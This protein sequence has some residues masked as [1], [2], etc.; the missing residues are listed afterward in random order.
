M[1]LT[2][3]PMRW[4]AGLALAILMACTR[5]NHFASIHALPSASWAVFFLA[6]AMLGRWWMYALYFALASLLDFGSLA[7][8]TIT[9][10]CLSPAYWVLLPAYGTLW[11]C[12]RFYA[13][14]HEQHWQT[15]PRLALVLVVAVFFTYL[16]SGGGYYMLSGHYAP[17]LSGFLPRIAH[18]YP[19]WL[20]VTAGYVGAALA[21][22]A[23]A[24]TL[25]ERS[26]RL[27]QGMHV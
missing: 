1:P 24:M 18:Y 13:R 25:D 3:T 6:G 12:G 7:A 16:I 17:T 5:G 23:V 14:W 27:Q 8:G 4:L 26:S 10:W 15:V 11:A 22:Q 21:L 2:S 20:G 9:D 19:H